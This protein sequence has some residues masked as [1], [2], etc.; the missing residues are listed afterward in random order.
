MELTSK[1]LVSIILPTFNER[2]N[3][4]AVVEK[5]ASL[6]LTV[7]IIVVDD[8][9]PDGTAKAVRSMSQ[10]YPVRLISRPSKL[11]LASAII[12]GLNQAR[13]DYLVV[14]DADQSHDPAIIPELVKALDQG[15]DVAIGSRFVV[16]G[17]IIGWPI[18]RQAMSWLATRFAKVLLR[19]RE[20]D[21]LSGYF[22]IRHDF[23]RKLKGQL[24]PRGYKLL[25]EMLV[26]G[27]PVQTKEI[28]YV[29]QDRLYG[30][31]KLSWTITREYFSMILR[32]I[33]KKN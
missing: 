5:I 23:Y 20:Q 21:P 14:M 13:A 25:L 29:F 12:E 4:K 1:R 15:V 31:S 17:G 26:R 10:N 6:P 27:A 30:K 2:D 3:I 33:F 32:L 7:E 11:G 24:Q 28:G 18:R 16:G 8:D 9:S 19:V 22:A